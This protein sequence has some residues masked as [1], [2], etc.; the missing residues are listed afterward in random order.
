M[1]ETAA[2]QTCQALYNTLKELFVS[3]AS[4][5]LAPARLW[6]RLSLLLRLVRQAVGIVHAY[7]EVLQ[8]ASP[9][10]HCRLLPKHPYSRE[11]Y[12]EHTPQ[13]NK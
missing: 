5:A 3:R 6:V 13:W 11:L 4:S 1:L 9:V 2:E 10:S 12:H 8:Q 7:A